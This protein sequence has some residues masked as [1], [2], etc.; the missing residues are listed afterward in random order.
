MDDFDF[1]DDEEIAATLEM[2]DKLAN[3]TFY[4]GYEASD[5]LENKGVSNAQG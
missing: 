4:E 3:G 1:L 2:H 5:F